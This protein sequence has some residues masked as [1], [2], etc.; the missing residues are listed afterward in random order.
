MI[1]SKEYLV[2]ISQDRDKTIRERVDE[3]C[4]IDTFN[5]TELGKDSNH[6][7]RFD[8]LEEQRVIDE[9]IQQ[10]DEIIED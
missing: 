1:N 6:K 4:R 5:H 3:L 2:K 10:L 8:V 7:E 9:L